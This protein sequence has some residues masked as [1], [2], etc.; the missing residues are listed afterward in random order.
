MIRVTFVALAAVALVLGL[1]LATSTPAAEAQELLDCEDFDSQAEAQAYYRE[2]P[3]DPTDNDADEDGI[4]CELFAYED[5]ATDYEP[6]TT[7]VGADTTTA[8][9]T[10]T[11]AATGTGSALAGELAGSPNAFLLMGLLGAAVACG[12]LAVRG[13]RRFGAGA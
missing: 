11:M 2:N 4:A 13:L 9:T 5:S 12:A 10:T 7:A 8:T 6:V 3:D 1:G